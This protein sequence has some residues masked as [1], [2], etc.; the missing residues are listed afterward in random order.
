MAY[1]GNSQKSMDS[2]RIGR[3]PRARRVRVV[4]VVI[5]ALMLRRGVAGRKG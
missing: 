4:I 3:R 1:K 2:G 5:L